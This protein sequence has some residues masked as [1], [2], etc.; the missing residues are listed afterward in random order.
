MNKD[1][2]FPGKKEDERI[3]LILRKHWAILA[4]KTSKTV[5]LAILLIIAC[6]ILPKIF[7]VLLAE[8]LRPVFVLLISAYC[9]GVWLYF[10]I[11]WVDYYLDVWIITDERIIDVEQAG[12]LNR[13]SAEQKIYRVQDVTAEVKGLLQTFWGFGTLYVQTAGEEKRFTF[14]NIPDPYKVKRIIMDAYE[15]SL[16]KES[17]KNIL[18]KEKEFGMLKKDQPKDVK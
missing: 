12:L 8:E 7:P 17:V 2:L 16:E 6:I 5:F 13:V 10:F 14:E 18:L 4:G 9:L 3:L 11:N 1:I 15:K